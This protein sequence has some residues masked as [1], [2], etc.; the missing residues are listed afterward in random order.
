M[1][2]NTQ[3]NIKTYR[4]DNIS[5]KAKSIDIEKLKLKNIFLEVKIIIK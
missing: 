3:T 4:K 5:H 1:I 2:N